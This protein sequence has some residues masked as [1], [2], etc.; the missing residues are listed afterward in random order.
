MWTSIKTVSGHDPGVK[1][2]HIVEVTCLQ[3][4]ILCI[5]GFRCWDNEATGIDINDELAQIANR[6]DLG[7][8]GPNGK[9]NFSTR[10]VST[11]LHYSECLGWRLH[12]F[13]NLQ[14]RL[15]KI[16]HHPLS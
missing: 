8:E 16:Y 10:I 1:V 13:E 6:A 7:E 14:K 2:G 12:I 4:N 5:A 11:F 3:E 9:Y 15:L